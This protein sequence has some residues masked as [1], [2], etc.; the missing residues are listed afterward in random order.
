[1]TPAAQTAVRAATC[2]TAPSGVRSST[3][4][5]STPT[6]VVSSRTVTPRCAS[7]R[8]ARRESDSGNAL[9]TRGPASTSSTRVVRVSMSRKSRRSASRASSAIWPAIS[10]P[11]GP[12]PTTT[13]VSHASPLRRIAD[14]D[15]GRLE[16]A[17]DAGAKLERA[18]ERLE[19]RRMGR[20]LVVAEVRVGRAAGDDEVVVIEQHV[21]FAVRHPA[22]PHA[23]LRDVELRR[24][25][26]QDARVLL[27]VQDPS[28]R[29]G[30][31]GSREPA[32]RDLVDERLEQV[33]VL[34]IDE[35]D[36]DIGAPQALDDEQPAE[37]AAD[38]HDSSA[39]CRRHGDSFPYSGRVAPS[40]RSSSRLRSSPPA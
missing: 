39:L 31:L 33:V 19:L 9:S 21:L 6:T 20:P 14:L 30:D 2:S 8:S 1:M 25:G 5:V 7:E 36:V 13:N 15:L 4:P 3:R 18:A 38:H 35:G 17:Q 29:R 10:T 22:E 40:N 23:P 26:E 32:G 11:V 27:A 16:R 37:A 28:Q 12:A 34:A 24:L